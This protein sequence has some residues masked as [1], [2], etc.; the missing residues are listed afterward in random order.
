MVG[1]LYP[2]LRTH[3]SLF[4]DSLYAMGDKMNVRMVVDDEDSGSGRTI[5]VLDIMRDIIRGSI[6]RSRVYDDDGYARREHQRK[7][8]SYLDGIDHHESSGPTHH[9]SFMPRL[10]GMWEDSAPN[11]DDEA[12]DHLFTFPTVDEARSEA[13][14]RAEHILRD[15]QLLANIVQKYE[16]TIQKRWLQKTREKRK[17]ILLKAWPDMP[18]CHRPDFQ[19]FKAR[20][21]VSQNSRNAYLWPYINVEDLTKPRLLPLFLN[22]RGRNEPSAFAEADYVACRFGF[23]VGALKLAK[24][25]GFIMRFIGRQKPDTY[26]GIY[27][28]LCGSTPQVCEWEQAEDNIA[29]G[30]GLIILEVQERVYNLLV[31]CCRLILH[32]IGEDMLAG[33]TIAVQP[34]PEST[35]QNETTLPPLATIASE[36]PY[37]LQSEFDLRHLRSIVQAK[38]SAAE[39]HLWA[40][41]EDPYY[42]STAFWE[43]ANHCYQLTG[44]GIMLDDDNWAHC[45]MNDSNKEHHAG[46]FTR[47]VVC[48]AL[49]TAEIWRDLN[50]QLSTVLRLREESGNTRITRTN[51]GRKFASEVMKLEH[52]LE[53]YL[54]EPIMR[55]ERSF[56]SSPPVR[57]LLPEAC[58]DYEMVVRG[59][60]FDLDIIK[61]PPTKELFWIVTSLRNESQRKLAGFGLLVDEL[62]QLLESSATARDCIS[63]LVAREISDLSVLAQC[64]TFVEKYY[65]QAVH[66]KGERSSFCSEFEKRMIGWCDIYEEPN[67]RHAPIALL[68]DPSDGKFSY[69]VDQPG[70]REALEAAWKAEKQLD[71][72]WKEIDRK[73]RQGKAMPLSLRMLVA[74]RVLQRTPK[75]RFVS[76]QQEE[77]DLLKPLS[78][79]DFEREQRTERTLAREK[80]TSPKTKTKTKGTG[81]PVEIEPAHENLPVRQAQISSESFAVDKR[82]LKAF[83]TLFYIPGSVGQPGEI[84]W[85]NFLHAMTSIGF[86]AQKLYGSVWQFSPDRLEAERPIQFHEPHPSGK[87]PFYLARHVGRRLTRAYGWLGENF[88]LKK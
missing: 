33:S 56:F 32:D 24:L 64:T 11:E 55:L 10:I 15:W 16:A 35:L 75:P 61:D 26:G 70:N 25:D 47:E 69:P 72:L 30:A 38:L 78:E 66:S 31:S 37:K 1:I 63:P 44:N 50:Q 58:L 22:S 8:H 28:K 36:A 60:S 59:E 51:I 83:R 84:L 23:P 65:P 41:R 49:R 17:E 14:R 46:G 62:G 77:Q 29:P 67:W 86:S 81:R 42:F 54:S 88:V 12:V 5:G 19:D 87:L 76:S 45:F 13:R 9:I 53:M 27:P 39:D 85:A 6:E 52:D 18:S 3:N 82:A 20:R 74:D 68:G 7:L 21:K 43:E 71:I 40:L 80:A 73:L 4:R 79:I 57:R 34:E 2:D 48:H